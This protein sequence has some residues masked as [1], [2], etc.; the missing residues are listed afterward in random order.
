MEKSWASSW[1][2]APHRRAASQGADPVPQGPAQLLALQPG[3]RLRNPGL[4]QGVCVPKLCSEHSL[5]LFLLVGASG[6]FP[7]HLPPAHPHTWFRHELP[8]LREDTSQPPPPLPS[9][10][11]HLAGPGGAWRGASSSRKASLISQ[12]S[13]LPGPPGLTALFCVCCGPAGRQCRAPASLTPVNQE[14][15]RQ[16]PPCKVS[17]PTCQSGDVGGR[18]AIP[19]SVTR[20]APALELRLG[21]TDFRNWL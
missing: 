17:A 7:K 10:S 15:H 6:A 8:S 21:H 9:N 13:V 11:P 12:A 4:A 3:P 16:A 18:P 20:N 14:T 5:W 2:P 1:H 19:L